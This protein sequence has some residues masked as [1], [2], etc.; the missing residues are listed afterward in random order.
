[1]AAPVH[2]RN[3]IHRHG[4]PFGAIWRPYLPRY[5]KRGADVLADGLGVGCPAEEKIEGVGVAAL[6][7]MPSI[8]EAVGHILSACID[9]L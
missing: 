3:Q 9:L 8:V 5:L 1:M 2:R 7:E 6:G 4:H